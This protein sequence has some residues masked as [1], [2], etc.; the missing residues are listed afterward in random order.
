MM[1][2]DEKFL[3]FLISEMAMP[4]PYPVSN[5]RRQHTGA[6]EQQ[7]NRTDWHSLFLSPSYYPFGRDLKFLLDYAR[8]TAH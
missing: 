8:P 5:R 3:A 6:S 2:K 4:P 1:W 7:Q